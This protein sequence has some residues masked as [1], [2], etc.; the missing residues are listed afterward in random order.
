MISLDVSADANLFKTKMFHFRQM[1]KSNLVFFFRPFMPFQ[2]MF[3][4]KY[5]YAGYWLTHRF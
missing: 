3:I 1:L 2:M 5:S 4:S